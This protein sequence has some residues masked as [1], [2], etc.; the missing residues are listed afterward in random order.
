MT[1]AIAVLDIGMTNKK[2]V[3][4]STELSM[5]AEKRRIFPP[6]VR[7]GLEIHDLAA[8]E[9]WFLQVLREYSRE[10]AI[11][12]LAVS[13]HGA[14]FVCTDERGNP[15]APC[16][17]YTHEPSR[18]FHDRFFA[19]AGDR[20]ELQARTGTPDLSALINS[21]KGLLFLRERYPEEFASARWI[22]PY[23]QYWGMRLTGKPSA[24]GTYIGCHTFLFDW[25]QESYSSVADALGIRDKLPLPIQQA[26]DVL[27][28]IAPEVAART[29]LS[30]GTPVTLGIHD[31]NASILPHLASSGGRDFVLNSTGT[32]CV[33]MHPVEKYGFEPDELGK[34]V[35][36]NRSAWNT[37][38]KTAIFL[39]GK[40]YETWIQIIAV[41]QAKAPK[42]LLQPTEEDYER[43]LKERKYFILPE[44]VPGSGQFPG[45]AA[46]A[47]EGSLQC[48]LSDVEQGKNIPSF[49]RDPKTAQAVLNI[50]IVLQTEVALHRTGLKKS[51]DILTEGGFRN[52]TD[53]NRLLASA[54]PDNSVYLTDL[55]EATSF[56][57][58]MTALAALKSIDPMEFSRLIHIEKALVPPMLPSAALNAYRDAWRA[59]I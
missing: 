18:E 6:L 27:G 8:M 48:T 38:I 44:I 50:S 15:V 31:S 13:T 28:T 24:E 26:W 14:T 25:Q 2:V 11:Q 21:A 33:L 32:W 17:Y 19:L 22:L 30:P 20:K 23:P 45:S 46:R 34:V 10:F 4:Y 35:F 5:I 7:E 52:N 57:A 41:L 29:G 36:F 42:N 59:L 40:E 43:V 3:L 53:Y 54:F 51:A 16:I 56:G 9:E 49:L 37:P 39:G 12:A 58:A 47:V 55:Q 1:D